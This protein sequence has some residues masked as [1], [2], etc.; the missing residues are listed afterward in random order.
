MNILER[1]VYLFIA[2][3]HAMLRFAHI[4]NLIGQC[5]AI[6]LIYAPSW[7]SFL[8]TFG[9]V[10]SWPCIKLFIENYV[11]SQIGHPSLFSD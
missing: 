6:A 2:E 3:G 9:C 5:I 4:G 11:I 7:I 1:I 10:M 8:I